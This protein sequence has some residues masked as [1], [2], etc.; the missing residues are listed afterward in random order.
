MININDTSL[1]L[2]VEAS[3]VCIMTGLVAFTRFV[4]IF[5][6]AGYIGAPSR[7]KGVGYTSDASYKQSYAVRVLCTHIYF[8]AL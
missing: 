2:S 8:A 1:R 5:S 6:Q 7:Q 4:K 3:F